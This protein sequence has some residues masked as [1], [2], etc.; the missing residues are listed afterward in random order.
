MVHKPVKNG[1]ALEPMVPNKRYRRKT[2]GP[3][4]V[5]VTDNGDVIIGIKNGGINSFISTVK[6]VTNSF[7]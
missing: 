3:T 1:S 6:V 5:C 4:E 7:K 2:A